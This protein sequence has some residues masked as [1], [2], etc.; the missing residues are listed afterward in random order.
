MSPTQSSFLSAL[1]VTGIPNFPYAPE[2]CGCI[3]KGGA[4]LFK[5]WHQSEEEV[6]TGLEDTHGCLDQIPESRARY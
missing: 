1:G 2:G 4:Q 6:R 3:K 5:A